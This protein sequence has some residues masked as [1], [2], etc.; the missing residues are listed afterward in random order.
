MAPMIST[1]T[2]PPDTLPA[3]VLAAALDT[4]EAAIALLA[5]PQCRFVFANAAFHALGAGQGERGADGPFTCPAIDSAVAESLQSGRMARIPRFGVRMAQDP[6]ATW[7]GEVS[8]AGAST[9]GAPLLLICIRNVSHT[10]RA[11]RALSFSEEALRRTNT[12]LR[13]TL[14][15]ITDGV[16]VMDH[17][18]RY[19]F[20]SARA[21]A[22]I[23]IPAEKLVG[24][25]VWELFP[26]AVDT[27]FHACYHRAAT[28][29]M[30]V[31]F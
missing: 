9:D 29:G 8:R 6:D 18:W 24:G 31:H 20:V 3:S 17:D 14:D 1:R 28:T 30:P 12:K 15:N 5:M 21:A 11:E 13:D 19:T 25:I 26:A 16:L 10:V 4:S 23:G 7:E 27:Q 22:I 2:E